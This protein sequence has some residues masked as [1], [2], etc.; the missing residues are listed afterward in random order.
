MVD[1]ACVDVWSKVESAR[2]TGGAVGLPHI[3]SQRPWVRAVWGTGGR[4]ASTSS[5][6]QTSRGTQVPPCA[7][8]LGG[9][10]GCIA[11]RE[12]N[13]GI[14]RVH[15]PCRQRQDGLELRLPTANAAGEF[16][17]SHTCRYLENCC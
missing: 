16:R 15:G 9:G 13:A 11:E 8:S 2:E 14:W 6:P 12:R 3:L 1:V 17:P 4:R 7:R 10:S 5:R